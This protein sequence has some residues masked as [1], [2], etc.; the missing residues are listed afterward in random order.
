MKHDAIGLS[1]FLCVNAGINFYLGYIP[2]HFLFAEHGYR[3]DNTAIFAGAVFSMLLWLCFA[4][5]LWTATAGPA[6]KLPPGAIIGLPFAIYHAP[7][8]TCYRLVATYY[9]IKAAHYWLK[10]RILSGEVPTT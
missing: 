10:A 9:E 6:I 3:S 1:Q 5:M 8:R 4:M 2:L 7:K